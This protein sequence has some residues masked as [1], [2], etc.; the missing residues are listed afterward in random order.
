MSNLLPVKTLAI[1]HTAEEKMLEQRRVLNGEQPPTSNWTEQNEMRRFIA[2]YYA[3]LVWCLTT[4]DETTGA[5]SAISGC[6]A[7]PR[8]WYTGPQVPAVLTTCREHSRS[9]WDS[10]RHTPTGA[11]RHRER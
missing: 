2:V 1:R 3:P 4:A 5:E 11:R 6:A 9:D 7:Q 8:R 10:W